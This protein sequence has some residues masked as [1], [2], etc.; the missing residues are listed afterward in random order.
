VQRSLGELEDMGLVSRDIKGFKRVILP[1]GCRGASPQGAVGRHQEHDA[2]RHHNS[3][4]N[5]DNITSE[6]GISQ[7]PIVEEKE[8]RVVKRPTYSKKTTPEARKV[9]DIF[10]EMFGRED[11]YWTRHQ[12]QRESAHALYKEHE[13]GKPGQIKKALKIYLEN[14]DHKHC[15][16]IHN[17]YDLDR[18]WSNLIVFRDKL[19]AGKL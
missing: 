6:I 18:K 3:D 19:E 10:K 12:A 13:E 1:G 4:S 9:I 11:S 8:E 15:P 14:Q 5:S 2:G 7:E 17:P 16:D